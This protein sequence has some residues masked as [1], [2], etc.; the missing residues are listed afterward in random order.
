MH[1]EGHTTTIKSALT[2]I[3]FALCGLIFMDDADLFCMA[4]DPVTKA[5]F[6]VA[7]IQEAMLTW[8]DGLW[9]SGGALKPSKCSWGL[10]DFKWANRAWRHATEEDAPAS[11]RV[12]NLEGQMTTT[13]RNA[14]DKAVEVL[15]FWQA[16]DGNMTTQKG[17]C[18]KAV[19]QWG[20][21]MKATWCPHPTAWTGL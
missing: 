9:C 4:E 19:R 15:G 2:G 17:K 3:V 21:A 13:K 16:M 8:H 18:I 20:E 1:A 14:P 7:Q 12:P 5:E 6:I 11:T 10:I